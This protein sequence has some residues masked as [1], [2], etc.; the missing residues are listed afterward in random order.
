MQFVQYAPERGGPGSLPIKIALMSQADADFWHRFVQPDVASLNGA[1][2][3]WNWS[4]M[5][6]WLPVVELARGR[7]APAYTVWAEGANNAAVPIAMTLLSEGYSALHDGS[8]RSIYVWFMAAAPEP[9]LLR[10]GVPMVPKLGRVLVDIAV[11]HSHNCGYGGCIGLHAAPA[12]GQKL[13]D[14]YGVMGLMPLP[15]AAGMPAY[16]R[17]NDG[18]YFYLNEP[19]AQKWSNSLSP[20]R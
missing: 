18:R 1:D 19:E 20:Y 14:I 2:A 3:K 5:R 17:I 6:R 10:Y 8:K 7:R 13:L 15:A 12:G 4:S 16:L 9:T 11:T